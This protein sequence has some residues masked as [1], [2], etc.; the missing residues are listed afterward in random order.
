MGKLEAA[1]GIDDEDEE[2]QS[3]IF[4]TCTLVYAMQNIGQNIVKCGAGYC[5]QNI[6]MEDAV[7]QTLS[8]L[9]ECGM[10]NHL[11]SGNKGTH[12]MGF[13][14]RD[15][16]EPAKGGDDPSSRNKDAPNSLCVAE[17]IPFDQVNLPAAKQCGLCDDETEFKDKALH[18]E[19]QLLTYLRNF[20]KQADVSYT[21]IF[22][23]LSPCE[24]CTS[25]IEKFTVEFEKVE[26][27]IRYSVCC[28]LKEIIK[29][30][31]KGVDTRPFEL[32]VRH[33]LFDLMHYYEMEFKNKDKRLE[34][35]DKNRFDWEEKVF[36]K[37][38]SNQQMMEPS[39]EIP[40]YRIDSAQES[41]AS[42]RI[43]VGFLLRIC[44][45]CLTL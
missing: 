17:S 4:F 29:L 20:I 37:L 41:A 24:K 45:N 42:S 13:L 22:I 32:S 33:Q 16:D 5:D 40:S 18:A 9:H 12:A 28:S 34:M 11:Q 30:N 35:D 21:T 38:K 25:W 23:S 3:Y 44:I 10:P 31:N 6:T 27:C 14:E 39:S 15:N 1:S 43:M 7:K 26:I 19:P 36:P 8:R 2:N